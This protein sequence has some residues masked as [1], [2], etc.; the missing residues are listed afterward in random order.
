MKWPA[1]ALNRHTAHQSMSHKRQAEGIVYLY[2]EAANYLFE[3]YA[4]DDI[5]ADTDA[6][7]MHFTKPSRTVPEKYVNALG[8]RSVFVTEYMTNIH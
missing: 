1:T 4:E 5:I 7:M 6:D 2:S 3:T 8:I